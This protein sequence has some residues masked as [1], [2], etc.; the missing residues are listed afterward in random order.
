M[1]SEEQIRKM[2]E[3]QLNSQKEQLTTDY[4]SA[5]SELD[6]QKAKNQKAVDASLNRTAAEAQQAAVNNEEYYAASGLSSGAKAQA[7]L[8]LENQKMANMTALRA[9]Q[10]TADA[11]AERQRGLLSKEYAAAIRKAQADNDMALAQALYEQA[12][13]E[14]QK[15]LA[16]Q[17]AAAN[18]MAQTGD[19]TRFGALYGLSDDEV[20]KLSGGNVGGSGTG[21]GGRVQNWDNGGYHEETVKQL[22][23]ALGFTG[24]DVDGL[25]GPK[26]QAEAMKRW[27]VSS[28]KEA[29]AAYEN[30]NT[31]TWTDQWGSVEFSNPNVKALLDELKRMQAAGESQW[32]RRALLYEAYKNDGLLTKEEYLAMHPRA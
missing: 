18:L 5:L 22:Q 27:N 10:Q 19:Y 13:K 6:A 24:K 16:Q 7:R 8:S 1:N 32:N 30:D 14:E 31:V 29:L 28:V 2:Y 26:S 20:R 23:E 4:E 12:E 21:N 15:L 25:W 17:E 9:A 3:G 11:E